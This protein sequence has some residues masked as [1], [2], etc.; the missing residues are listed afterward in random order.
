MSVVGTSR[1][2]VQ[3]SD[4]S[5]VGGGP[6]VSERMKGYRGPIRS[7]EVREKQWASFRKAGLPE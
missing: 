4:V 3:C 2:L 1:H 5:D 6:E 7:P